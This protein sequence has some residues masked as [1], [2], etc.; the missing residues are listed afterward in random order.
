MKK[1]TIGD[2]F[3]NK[4]RP[5]AILTVTSLAALIYAA[6]NVAQKADSNKKIVLSTVKASN[7][8]VPNKNTVSSGISLLN[9]PR[10]ATQEV[11]QNQ[12]IVVLNK[13]T[14]LPEK[15]AAVVAK[16]HNGKVL[17][18]YHHAIQGFTVRLPGQ[19]VDA[20]LAAMQR[21]PQ[22]NYVEQDTIVHA[23]ETTQANPSWGL[24]RIDQTN[25]PL[26]GNYTY[27]NTGS[28]VNAY[29]VDSGIQAS[30]QE[31]IGRVQT[32]YSTVNDL[33]GTT[34][35]NGHGTHVSGIVG[36]TTYGVAKNVNL[37]PVRVLD[38]AGSGSMSAVIAGLDWIVQN[39]KKPAVVNISLGGSTY[40]TL[41]T[42][43]DNL[44]NNGFLPV[45]AAGNSN[46]DACT[47]SPA[48]ATNAITVAATDNTDTRASYSNYGSCV[49]LFAPGSNITSAWIGTNTATATANGT[50]MAAPH[51]TGI[52]AT[53]LEAT[54]TATPQALTDQL[55]SQ[56]TF[57]LVNNV[58][59]SP[60]P[61][62]FSA[63]S[64]TNT[65]AIIPATIVHIQNL[66]GYSNKVSLLGL[67]RAN[68]GI[69]VTDSN[70]Q[71]VPNATVTGSFSVGGSS[72]GCTTNSAGQCQLNSGN[73]SR[74]TSKTTFT[75][76]TISGTNMTYAASSN[77]MSAITVYR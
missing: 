21:N 10:P 67:W 61:L 64:P 30:H 40:S 70:N 9:S 72:V 11:I 23:T 43:V 3:V 77:V 71:A 68:I 34:D 55:L 4:L 13:N 14:E 57:N 31:F 32:G 50:S 56:A 69:T 27:T 58:L 1:E 53:L 62:L 76:K 36:G 39:G 73:I 12:F 65:A 75:I 38:C 46:T 42:A 37:I 49:D 16:A 52:I 66:S 47:M 22:V 7:T 24:D 74:L 20:F 5:I 54:P 6:S 63:L 45:V 18:T 25:L 17:Y 35:C 29:I 33:N 26:N 51:V 8:T 41:D 15:A 19:A 44:Y 59:G 28:G 60:N 48:R 2:S